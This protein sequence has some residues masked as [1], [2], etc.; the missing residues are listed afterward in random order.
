MIKDNNT[1]YI[2]KCLSIYYFKNIEIKDLIIENL[3]F[4]NIILMKK[5]E[6]IDPVTNLSTTHLNLISN[7]TLSNI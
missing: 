7:F 3:A 4:M 2:G 1:N 6:N 5:Y